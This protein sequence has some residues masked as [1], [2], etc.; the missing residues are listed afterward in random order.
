M[1]ALIF[2]VALPATS[3]GQGRGRG[4][5]EGSKW[6]KKCGKFVNCHDASDG[7]WDRRGPR[8]NAS[9]FRNGIIFQQQRARQRGH[10]FDGRYRYDRQRMLYP[11][12]Y[13]LQDRG[14]R[15]RARNWDRRFVVRHR[16]Y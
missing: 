6:D 13:A 9:V 2:V 10:Y 12:D 8:R 4:R 11:Y 15:L 7:R 3:L 1:L 14:T 5:W 16:R